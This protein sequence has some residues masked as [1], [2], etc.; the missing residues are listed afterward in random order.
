MRNDGTVTKVSL[1][2]WSVLGIAVCGVLQGMCK[3][4][5]RKEKMGVVV[6][7]EQE[8]IHSGNHKKVGFS[9]EGK[10]GMYI[11]EVKEP[12]GSVVAKASGV[13]G[14]VI[15][16]DVSQTGF[17]LYTIVIHVEDEV[18]EVGI[19]KVLRSITEELGDRPL[20]KSTWSNREWNA[21]VAK[22]EPLPDRET[23]VT[24]EELASHGP[25]ASSRWIA[26]AGTVYDVTAFAAHHPGGKKVIE[27]TCSGKDSTSAFNRVHP[28]VRVKEL[29]GKFIVGD[30]EKAKK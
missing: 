12:N 8:V 26:I 30:L 28:N 27:V 20:Q 5:F 9:V 1:V 14:E 16:V 2:N 23:L 6:R 19:R 24:P 29:L 7:L 3:A 22:Q 18:T 4:Y 21:L 13:F 11:Y 17:G 25:A 15:Y 10:K